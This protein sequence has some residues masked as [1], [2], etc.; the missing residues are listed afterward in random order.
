MRER[1]TQGFAI[2]RQM[3]DLVAARLPQQATGLR[4]TA[5]PAFCS[6]QA[7]LDHL[8]HFLW[9]GP[10]EHIRVSRDCRPRGPLQVQVLVEPR[11]AQPHPLG[12]PTE[13]GLFALLR[14][15]GPHPRQSQLA[16]D[17]V[18]LFRWIGHLGFEPPFEQGEKGSGQV[19]RYQSE[20]N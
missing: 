3:C 9:V 16:E 15:H 2:Q 8:G 13:F 18:H 10:V 20:R 5:S 1:A 11:P 4:S 7:V 12:D 19:L 14:E 6:C 17:L